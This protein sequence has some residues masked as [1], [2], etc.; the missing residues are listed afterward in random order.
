MSFDGDLELVHLARAAKTA[1]RPWAFSKDR[2]LGEFMPGSR[3]VT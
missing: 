1:T 2:R 3:P